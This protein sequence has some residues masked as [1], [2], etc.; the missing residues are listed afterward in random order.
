M[1][2]HALG[3]T[4]S[5]GEVSARRRREYVEQ[6]HYKWKQSQVVNEEKNIDIHPHTTPPSIH[7]EY[8]LCR[9]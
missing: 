9:K 3:R 1:K 2:T 4:S 5:W 8:Q 6:K 7:T